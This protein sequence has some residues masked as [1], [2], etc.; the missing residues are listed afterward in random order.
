MDN[1]LNEIPNAAKHADEGSVKHWRI[2][3]AGGAH[4]DV[5]IDIPANGA[6]LGGA[7]TDDIPIL[8]AEITLLKFKPV[9]GRLTIR[10]LC[11]SALIAGEQRSQG[12][13][14]AISQP[15]HIQVHGVEIDVGCNGKFSAEELTSE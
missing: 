3:F 10:V 12:E 13:K 7:E 15:V 5:E 9:D 6:R 8:D 2:R 14:V 4:A 1:N 11:E